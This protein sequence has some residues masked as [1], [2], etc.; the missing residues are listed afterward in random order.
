VGGILM[1]ANEGNKLNLL[2]VDHSFHKKTMS[3][4]FL[5]EILEKR[6]SVSIFWDDYWKG[7]KPLLVQEINKYDYV[8][9]FQTLLPFSKLKQIK[10]KIIW[11]PMFDGDPLSD[12][13]WYCLSSLP[14][15]I[16]S[17]SEYLHEKCLKYNI[18]SL[19]LKYYLSPAFSNDIPKTGRHYFFWYRGSLRFSDIKALIDPQKVDS[20]IYRSAP[21]PYFKEEVISN[22]DIQKYKL[23]II[24]DMK[25]DTQE[26]YLELLKKSNIYLAPRK[27]EG[28]GLSFLEAM[29]IGMVVVA[30][31][32]GTMNEYIKHDYNG[33][34][35]DS[36]DYQINFDNIMT[37][38][39]NSKTMVQ[40]GW[41]KWERD[42]TII[43]NFILDDNYK[44]TQ[45][46]YLYFFIYSTYQLS[47]TYLRKVIKRKI[48]K[49][50][51]LIQNKPS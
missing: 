25:L 41:E 36:K 51:G 38:L 43:N 34:L 40:K 30:Y 21:D 6:F 9:F 10:A 5:K 3:T 22:E 15:K 31:D 19:S 32:N 13:Y 37:V 46:R 50:T 20:F 11:V 27:I 49:V 48:V 42:K 4:N 39:N 12:M 35:F 18:E 14:I 28:I 8:F 29:A 33:Y 26:K 24:R 16:I 1:T 44:K 23:Q 2:W 47:E 45:I 17:F 7:G